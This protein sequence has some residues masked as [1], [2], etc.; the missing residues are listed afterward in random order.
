MRKIAFILCLLSSPALAQ[1]GGG[2]ISNPG[3][4]RTTPRV[5][6]C[7]TSGTTCVSGG[8]SGTSPFTVSVNPP[9][10][11]MDVFICGQGGVGG[12]GSSTG[13]LSGGGGG[14][15]G[16]NVWSLISAPAATY[17]FTNA[18]GST[19]FGTSL[20][21]ANAGSAGQ[22]GVATIGGIGGNGGTA[23]G[24]DSPLTGNGGDTGAIGVTAS[25]GGAGGVGGSSP[26]GGGGV[27]GNNGAGGNA[28]SCGGG[29]GGSSSGAGG[30]AG[31]GYLKVIEHFNY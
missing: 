28:T 7:S 17:A 9:T 23:T 5:S 11:W 26:L 6:V 18:A 1:V 4:V 31:T 20:L 30:T 22:A 8:F 19:T 12:A 13:L 25:V 21:T 16:G 10:I 27:G 15:A 24:G 29:G 2:G 3:V 14:G